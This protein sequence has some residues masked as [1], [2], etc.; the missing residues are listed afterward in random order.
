MT[1]IDFKNEK[2]VSA[3]AFTKADFGCILYLG[4]NNKHRYCI[5]SSIK[6]L[7]K[8]ILTKIASNKMKNDVRA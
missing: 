8:V 1:R 2:Y 4:T 3:V 6:F 7:Q 5:I